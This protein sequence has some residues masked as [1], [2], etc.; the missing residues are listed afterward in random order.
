LSLS[1]SLSPALLLSHPNS[2]IFS[3]SLSLS[4]TVSLIPIRTL[5][6][7]F[8]LSLR[9]PSLPTPSQF[10]GPY[11]THIYLLSFC[12]PHKY[13]LA[14]Q[15]KKILSRAR[16]MIHSW[17]KQKYVAA[18]AYFLREL[19]DDRPDVLLVCCVLQHVLQCVAGCCTFF[20]GTARRSPRSPSGV[21]QCVAVCCSVLQCVAVC[22]SVLQCVALQ[23]VAV[24]CSVLQCVEVCCSVLQYG[25]VCSNVLQCVIQFIQCWQR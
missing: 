22:C 24:C 7:F 5:S 4:L 23:C 8:S 13:S 17:Q 14:P 21:L 20:A 15:D 12:P 10:F 16:M 3:L 2:L 18:V 6:L 25:T 9:P 19:R 1:L 11:T